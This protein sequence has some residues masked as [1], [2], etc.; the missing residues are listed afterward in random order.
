LGSRSSGTIEG[1]EFLGCGFAA[2]FQARD[3]TEPAVKF[4]FFNAFGEVGDDFNDASPLSGINSQHWASDA[5]VFMLT[6]SSVGPA[7]GAEFEL[8][9]VEVLPKLDPFLFAWLAVFRLRPDASS[10]VDVRPVGA[11][12][13][14]G[15]DSKIVLCRFQTGMAEYLGGDM[16]GQTTRHR[17]GG[18]HPAEIVRHEPHWFTS[19]VSDSSLGHCQIQEPVDLLKI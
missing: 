15:K 14:I 5:S 9:F 12:H 11:N 8:A 17:F 10:L 19:R 4:G 3:L 1:G 13:L 16:H 2:G 6:G 7:A 18:E